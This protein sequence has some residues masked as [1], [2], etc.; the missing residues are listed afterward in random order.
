M[1]QERGSYNPTF[2]LLTKKRYNTKDRA[3]LE[4]HETDAETYL[5]EQSSEEED[6]EV[7]E[8]E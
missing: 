3:T 4:A 7:F 8:E 2:Y 1:E 6:D 5:G